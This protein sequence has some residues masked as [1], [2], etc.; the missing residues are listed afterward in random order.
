MSKVYSFRLN[1]NNPREAQAKE[2]IDIWVAEGYTLRRVIV[3]ALLSSH[4]INQ[5]NNESEETLEKIVYLLE[6]MNI[7]GRTAKDIQSALSDTFVGSISRS[8]KNGIRMK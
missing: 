3:D 6:N 1:D 4:R 2:V 7:A 5:K 8:V